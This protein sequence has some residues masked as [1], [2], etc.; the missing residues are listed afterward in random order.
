[1]FCLAIVVVLSTIVN[2]ASFKTIKLSFSKQQFSFVANEIGALEI[3]C[4]GLNAGF[5]SDLMQPGLPFV[6]VNVGIPD[7]SDFCGVMEHL[8][9]KVL[10]NDVVVA[11]TPENFHADYNSAVSQKTMPVYAQSS[12]PDKNVQY[13]CTDKMD[14]YSILRFLVC[15][16]RYDVQEKRLYLVTDISFDINLVESPSSLSKESNVG[17]QNMGDVVM[18]QIINPEDFYGVNIPIQIPVIDTCFAGYLPITERYVIVTSE[19]LAPY[20]KPLAQWKTQKGIKSKVV[21]V[22]EITALYP[23]M[24]IPLAIK[25]FFKNE[26]ENNNLKYALLGGSDCVVPARKCYAKNY[27]ETTV[28]P[29]D[30][31]YACFG[32]CFSWDANG[33]GIYGELEDSISMVP[34]IVVTRASVRD[35]SGAQAFVDKIL[36]YE[37][38]PDA[39]G[40]G[41]DILMCG[42]KRRTAPNGHS[43]SESDGEELF[44]YFIAP[45]WNGTRMRF[46]DT[47]TDFTEGADYDLTAENLQYELSKGYTFVDMITHGNSERWSLEAENK[48]YGKQAGELKNERYTIITTTACSTNMFDRPSP[49]L[50]EMFINNAYSGVV[51]YF[52]CSRYGWTGI[53]V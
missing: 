2:A 28:M 41:N 33:N 4:R 12:Y 27:A 45:Y 21:T 46:Y 48:Y 16:F 26:Y 43:D 19:E 35:V 29:A 31:Y 10:F 11:A 39:K 47:Y 14:G 30:L 1:M 17:G 3:S 51:A 20:F 25:T 8:S 49:C 15:P 52:G 23:N 42:A 32:N 34:D 53:F 38:D 13:V 22:E 9:T 24:D 37:K 44:K 40:W 50:G 6:A 18:S 7:G 5:I 36:G